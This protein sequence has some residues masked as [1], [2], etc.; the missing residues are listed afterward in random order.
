[1][2]IK[3]IRIT[4]YSY[5]CSFAF[6]TG[7]HWRL[8]CRW[9][10]VAFEIGLPRH[11]ESELWRALD[12]SVI[13]LAAVPFVQCPK[14]AFRPLDEMEYH[15]AVGVVDSGGNEHDATATVMHGRNLNSAST[16]DWF[17]IDFRPFIRLGGGAVLDEEADKDQLL[18]VLS[19]S[20]LV[21]DIVDSI[22]GEVGRIGAGTVWMTRHDGG[23]LRVAP[24]LWHQNFKKWC[25]GILNP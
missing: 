18:L 25:H 4:T 5:S 13:K 10:T 3:F 20:P 8:W 7:Y 1:M 24:F 23:S 15:L 12:C 22:I 19:L 9:E 6:A 21:E 16:R 14:T 11:T 2:S 17:S